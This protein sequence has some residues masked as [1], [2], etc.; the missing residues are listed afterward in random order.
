MENKV[1]QQQKF[2]DLNQLVRMSILKYIQLGTNAKEYFNYDGNPLPIRPLSTYEMDQIFLKVIKEGITQSTFKNLIDLKLNLINPNVKIPLNQE[3][4]SEFAKYYN[5]V[6]YWIVY[7]S[8]KDFQPEKFKMPDYEGEFRDKFVN[9]ESDNPKGYYI[10]KQMKYVHNI[11][12]DVKNMTSQPIEKLVEILR[13]GRGQALATR[14]FSL[15]TPL[16]SEA[17]KLTP[18]QHKFLYYGKP[19]APTLLT[20]ESELPGVKAGMT[21]REVVKILKGKD[22]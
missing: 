11:A 1:E 3:N 6:D 5:E 4:Y 14:V 15:N 22:V 12:R 7:N 13:N 20:D 10:V 21:M 2:K 17:W 16:A 8:M 9:W 18:L 19:G